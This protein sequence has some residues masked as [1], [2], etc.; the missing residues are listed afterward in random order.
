MYLPSCS[1]DTISSGGADGSIVVFSER[2]MTYP[3][4]NGIEDIIESQKPFIAKHN[5]SAGDLYVSFLS[6]SGPRS[7]VRLSSAFNLPAPSACL[8]A[9]ARPAWSS[10]SAVPTPSPPPTTSRSLSL[11]ASTNFLIV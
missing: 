6:Q 7:N 10:C 11:S 1:K 9:L 8:T 2:E 5:I 4:N 3:A